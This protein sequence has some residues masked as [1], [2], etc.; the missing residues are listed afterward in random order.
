MPAG[1]LDVTVEPLAELSAAGR[2]DLDA[3]VERVAA[4]PALTP[5]LTIGPITVGPHA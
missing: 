2:R 3:E 5:R 4:F 1:Y